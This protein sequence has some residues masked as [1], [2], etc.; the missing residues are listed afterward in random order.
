MAPDERTAELTARCPICGGAF[1]LS[2]VQPLLAPPLILLAGTASTAAQ[3]DAATGKVAASFHTLA[4]DIPTAEKPTVVAEIAKPLPKAEILT[5]EVVVEANAMDMATAPLV[6]E[7]SSPPIAA[8]PLPPIITAEVVPTV[9]AD[10]VG[11]A[12]I[13]AEMV[14]AAAEAVVVST[15]EFSIVEPKT[16]APVVPDVLP[17]V[18]DETIATPAT[19]PA[20]SKQPE[21]AVTVATE[22]RAGETTTESFDAAAFAAIAAS[23]AEGT[24]GTEGQPARPLRRRQEKN[25]LKEMIGIVLG[26]I[27]GL[28]IGYYLLNF[29]SNGK[30]NFLN[31][32]LPFVPGT[33]QSGST[34]E[35][36]TG[37]KEGGRERSSGRGTR[38]S[39][40]KAGRAGKGVP[41]G[42][43]GGPKNLP[44]EIQPFE[45]PPTSPA[46]PLSPAAP[47]ANP[48][49]GKQALAK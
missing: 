31:V 3:R 2:E 33:Y 5:A 16:A 25:P 20:A 28:A 44:T 41:Y 10:A 24:E 49:V 47:A 36:N 19:T 23:A 18:V 39:G 4:T 29:F 45:F 26:G 6:A 40:E 43:E 21:Q 7:P 17:M 37:G 11:P 42:K 35:L 12:A 48:G 13:T 9:A 8:E 22:P 30:H 1:S 32:W 34:P 14:A 46:S 38:E 27:A 15:G